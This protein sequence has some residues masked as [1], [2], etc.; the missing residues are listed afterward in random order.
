MPSMA[1]VTTR[2]FA[3]FAA[4]IPLPRSICEMIQPP[5]ISPLGFVSAG[6]AMVRMTSSPLGL[7]PD[8]IAEW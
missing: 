7:S 5:K 8:S 2:D 6:M 4:R 3:T 1:T